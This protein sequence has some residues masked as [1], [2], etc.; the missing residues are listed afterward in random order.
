[1]RGSWGWPRRGHAHADHEWPARRTLVSPGCSVGACG[2]S[3]G[4]IVGSTGPLCEHEHRPP[5]PLTRHSGSPYWRRPATARIR[6]L[7]RLPPSRRLATVLTVSTASGQPAGSQTRPSEEATLSVD[8]CCTSTH[9]GATGLY[10]CCARP[11]LC[12]PRL[13]PS[14]GSGN[15]NL[16]KLRRIHY[17]KGRNPEVK[18]CIPKPTPTPPPLAGFIFRISTSGGSIFR[19]PIPYRPPPGGPRIRLQA[20]PPS[21]G[22]LSSHAGRPR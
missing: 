17:L 6:S 1:M 7:P 12:G 20:R 4:E 11:H 5:S 22:W 21:S 10:K 19:P 14:G 9:G 18:T 15:R 16:Y 8:S 3:F 2:G 13:F